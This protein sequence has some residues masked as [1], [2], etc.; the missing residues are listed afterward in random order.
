MTTFPSSIII[1]YPNKPVSPLTAR[2]TISYSAFF[3]SCMVQRVWVEWVGVSLGWSITSKG[4]EKNPLVV[5]WIGVSLGLS[6]TRRGTGKDSSKVDRRLNWLVSHPRGGGD[7]R[8]DMQL[9]GCLV[10]QIISLRHFTGDQPAFLPITATICGK[11]FSVVSFLIFPFTHL[12]LNVHFWYVVC[13]TSFNQCSICWYL[14]RWYTG[15]YY[16]AHIRI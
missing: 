14:G 12:Q 10:E 4:W 11:K 3:L 15:L 6:I 16:C 7:L 5:G 8:I 1:V 13:N 2:V 9:E